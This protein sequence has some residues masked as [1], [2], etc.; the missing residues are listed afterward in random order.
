MKVK[1]F[2]EIEAEPVNMEGADHVFIRWLVSEKDGA[3]RF[4]MRLFEI[5]K[6]GRTPLHQ[7]QWEHEVFVLEGDGAVWKEGKEVTI[8]PGTAV[9]VPPEEK[10]CF[11]N[12]GENLFRFLCM[13]PIQ[14]KT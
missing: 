3:E 10:H 1:Q 5:Q 13:V 9:F 11:I 2:Q 14:K 7:H 6:D 4:A 8:P 12:K